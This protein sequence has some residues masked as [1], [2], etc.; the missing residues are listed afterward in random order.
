MQAKEVIELIKKAV[1][2]IEQHNQDVISV[3]ALK[4]YLEKLDKHVEEAQKFDQQ[5]STVDLEL[6]RAEHERNLAHYH[7]EHQFSL[8]MLR[9]VL[10]YGQTALKSAMLINGG[11]AAAI[12]AFIGNIWA[13][14]TAQASVALLTKSIAFFAF[15]V[16]VAAFGTGTSYLTQ[17][18][19]SEEKNT[20]A[21]IFHIF[22]IL[23]VL[24]AYFLFGMGAYKAYLAFVEHLVPNNVL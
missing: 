23:V 5:R 9:S 24:G 6:F 8:E 16:L 13:K 15:G 22:T 1:L 21:I 11:A 17:Y 20:A 14:G 4:N 7:V 3:N 18:F 2:Y 10:A 12:L 19:Y